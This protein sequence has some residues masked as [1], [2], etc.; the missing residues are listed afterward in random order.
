MK[1]INP[2]DF[3]KI[4]FVLMDMDG[5]LSDGSL[6][7]LPDG[8]IVKVFHAHDGYGIERGRQL[9][10]RFGVISGKSAEANRYRIERLKIE[11][12]YESRS[13]KV[14]AF[15]EIK[16]KHKLREENFC[17]IGDDVFD[18]PLLSR[19]A[20]SCAPSNAIKEVKES[21]HYVTETSGGKG[22]VREAI[23]FILRKKKLI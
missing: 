18:M 5:V 1:D 23:D 19:V 16:A 4:T 7:Y 14:E 17:F 12:Y 2:V 21:V 8:G 22:A 10:L 15:E 13:N 11:E 20:F 3:S 6:I 9:G